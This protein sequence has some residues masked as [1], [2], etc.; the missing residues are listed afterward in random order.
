MSQPVFSAAGWS[1]YVVSGRD[2]AA[3]ERGDRGDDLEHR[4]GHV[5]ALRRARQ[6]RL[7]VVGPE[8]RR[9]SR[10][11]VAGLAT[12]RRRRSGVET[13]AR[14]SP[15]RGSSMHDRAAVLGPAPPPRPAGAR[16]TSVVRRSCGS[17]GSARNLRG[18]LAQ[19][20]G[21]DDAAQLGVPGVLEA[22]GPEL[23]RR[24]ADD[25]ATA[26]SRRRRGTARRSGRACSRRGATPSRS[27][28]SPRRT[29][30][31]AAMT[32]ASSPG[33]AEVRRF[34]DL[35]VAGAERRAR[36]TRW[37]GPA[38]RDRAPRRCRRG[39]RPTTAREP[40]TG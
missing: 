15:V 8:R 29:L 32:A 39:D 27:K 21:R 10:V 3:A 18:Q 11:A 35:P 31:A 38:R 40:E 28:I 22:G 9:R 25:A 23:A 37:R 16:A 13:R 12:P 19:R 2:R 17:D 1:A 36:R 26:R 7:A 5:Q 20:V 24:V 6:E 34:D 30:R 33:A 14:T 4:A